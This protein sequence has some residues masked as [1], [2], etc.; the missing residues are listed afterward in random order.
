MFGLTEY[1]GY[2][3]TAYLIGILAQVCVLYFLSIVYCDALIF[4][5][6]CA[7]FYVVFATLQFL[8]FM[9]LVEQKSN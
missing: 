5:H 6:G 7:I 4:G 1:Q 9:K 2:L 8:L 3:F